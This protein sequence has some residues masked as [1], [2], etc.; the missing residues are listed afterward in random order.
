M[1]PSWFAHIPSLTHT[2][3]DS[4]CHPA[5]LSGPTPVESHPCPHQSPLNLHLQ[6]VLYDNNRQQDR[7][8]TTVGGSSSGNSATT[9]GDVALL[10]PRVIARKELT[11]R[12]LVVIDPGAFRAFQVRA[13]KGWVLCG[14]GYMWLVD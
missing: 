8:P 1:S 7:T 14:C 4:P 13:G 5:C 3:F 12:E 11:D 2:A 10:D 6:V 9:G